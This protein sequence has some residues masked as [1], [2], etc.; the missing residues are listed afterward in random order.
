MKQGSAVPQPPSLQKT[1]L[2]ENEKEPFAVSM[3][4]SK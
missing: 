3:S 4:G 2:K 1:R